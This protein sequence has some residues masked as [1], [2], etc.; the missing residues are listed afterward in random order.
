MIE[1]ELENALLSLRIEPGN[2]ITM[3]TA[4]A[5]ASS[6][7]M[8]RRQFRNGLWRANLDGALTKMYLVSTVLQIMSPASRLS[9]SQTDHSF[10]ERA[11]MGS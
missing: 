5:R 1:Y 2:L 3:S 8:V 7:K 6:L 9:A 11:E 10:G 4:G